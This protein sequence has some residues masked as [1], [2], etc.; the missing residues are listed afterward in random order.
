[1]WCSGWLEAAFLEATCEVA[2]GSHEGMPSVNMYK[3][4]HLLT[5][6]RFVESKC[7]CFVEMCVFLQIP[8]KS[9][10]TQTTW[11][12]GC[13]HPTP[14]RVSHN[15][16]IWLCWAHASMLHAML[17]HILTYHYLVTHMVTSPDYGHFNRV[18]VWHDIM[19]VHDVY[20]TLIQVRP[21]SEI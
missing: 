20:M 3:S 18:L 4:L 1:M 8:C 10:S 13:M 15:M 7:L 21:H 19:L 11:G 17:S 14:L 16:I 2:C 9:M 12:L 6:V 5:K